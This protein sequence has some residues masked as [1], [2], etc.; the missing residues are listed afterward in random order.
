MA[1]PLQV[2]F[3]DLEDLPIGSMSIG[4]LDPELFCYSRN[5]SMG[6]VD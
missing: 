4:K 3:N 5:A 6:V 2:R 1:L